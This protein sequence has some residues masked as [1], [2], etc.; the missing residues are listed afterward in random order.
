MSQLSQLKQQVAA[1]GNDAKTTSQGLAGF[2]QKFSS[3]IAQVSA[4]VGGSTQGVDKN[5][6]QTL[7]AAEKAVDQ[8]IRA[9][10]SAAQTAN[11]YSQSL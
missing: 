4:L 9:L 2:K 10:Q 1:I 7:Q 11:R 3:S 5:I 6:I 8:A